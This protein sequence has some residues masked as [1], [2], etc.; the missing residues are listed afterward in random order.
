MIELQIH[1]DW[2][3]ILCITSCVIVLIVVWRLMGEKY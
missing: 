3:E 2:G 1:A